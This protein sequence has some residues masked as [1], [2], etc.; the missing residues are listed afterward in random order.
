MTKKF[1]VP[2][3]KDKNLELR[4]ENDEVCIYATPIGL[5]K[6]IKFCQDLLQN[7]KQGH[8][9]LEDYEV[10]TEAS[11]KGVIAVMPQN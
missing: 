5:K 3:F 4:F 9:H 8:I 10:L 7:P 6:L 11:L 1:V 2:H